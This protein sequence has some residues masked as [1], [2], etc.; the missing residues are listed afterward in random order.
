[1]SLEDAFTPHHVSPLTSQWPCTVCQGLE[2]FR[3]IHYLCVCVC[4]REVNKSTAVWE[5]AALSRQHAEFWGGAEPISIMEDV[6]VC[7]GQTTAI[8]SPSGTLCSHSLVFFFF[9][10]L[11]PLHTHWSAREMLALQGICFWLTAIKPHRKIFFGIS[12]TGWPVH[13]SQ[14]QTFQVKIRGMR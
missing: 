13:V 1:M 11:T 8:D 10:S 7:A 6:Q 4:L 9:F 14:K 5:L 12:Y 3:H 2:L